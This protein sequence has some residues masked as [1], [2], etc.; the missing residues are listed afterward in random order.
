MNFYQQL[1]HDTEAARTEFLAV[2]F[3]TAGARG[4][5]TREQYLAFLTEAYHH[6]KHTVPLLMACGARLPEHLGWLRGA[7]AEYIEEEMGHE[8][9][10]LNDIR[11][12]GGNADAVRR[13]A[14]GLPTEIMVAY[15]YDT[16]TRHNPVSFF[17]MVFVL[18][19]TSVQLA[20]RAAQ[21]MQVNL[22]LPPRAFSYLLSH[23]SLDMSHVDFYSNL[24]NRLER[25]EDKN[26]ILHA[27]RVFYRLYG[28]IFRD[29]STL[30]DKR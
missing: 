7:I 29:L 18:E 6:V 25:L 28:D 23:G 12:S 2:P 22:G 4:A 19:G 26:A 24:V 14:P 1:V 27:A 5:V 21:A 30:L 11:E 3:L 15:A 8:E 10:I 17:G 9:W 20:T 16:I 13:S